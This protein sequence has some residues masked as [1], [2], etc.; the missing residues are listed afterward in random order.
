MFLRQ[1]IAFNSTGGPERYLIFSSY[2]CHPFLLPGFSH[3]PSYKIGNLVVGKIDSISKKKK[4]HCESGK[5]RRDSD[6]R[7]G[8]EEM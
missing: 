4:A 3:F 1:C 6:K 5:F 2:F 7:E 8:E